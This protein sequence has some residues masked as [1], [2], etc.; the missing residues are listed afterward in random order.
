MSDFFLNLGF[1]WTWSKSLPYVLCFVLGVVVFFVFRSK[2]KPRWGRVPFLLVI[3]IPF[4]IYFVVNPIYEG[5]FSNDY[6]TI[7][8]EPVFRLTKNELTVLAI[9]N[10]PFCAGAID[11]LNHIVER[12]EVER[13]NFIVITDRE[14]DLQN[15][16]RLARKEIDVSAIP[17]F[18]LFDQITVGRFPTFVYSDGNR[19]SVW[20]NDGFG[21][22]AI[23]WV[24][25]QLEETKNKK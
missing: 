11:R 13:I 24:E 18:K 14:E 3:P 15:Y 1:S 7:K 16:R 22:R 25:N 21:V 2:V 8:A 9:P 12:T 4:V 23:D 10:C 5:D 17:N 6:R 19:L 20:H